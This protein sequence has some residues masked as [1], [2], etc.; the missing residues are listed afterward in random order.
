MATPAPRGKQKPSKQSKDFRVVFTNSFALRFSDN[1]VL[2]RFSVDLD[3]PDQE[4]VALEEVAVA[5]TP[6]SAKL[7]ALTLSKVLESFE[8]AAG[9][10]DVPQ[11]KLDALEEA[12]RGQR[13]RGRRKSPQDS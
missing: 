6:R 9:P 3:P 10:I 12:I 4:S 2:L 11:D 8:S 5:M 7:L 13:F 1:D